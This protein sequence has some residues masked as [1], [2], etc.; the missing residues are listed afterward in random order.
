MNEPTERIDRGT[1]WHDG[2]DAATSGDVLSGLPM[3]NYRIYVERAPDKP[4][5]VRMAERFHG[6]FPS[7]PKWRM[8]ILIDELGLVE[9]SKLPDP[10]DVPDEVKKAAAFVTDSPC[11]SLNSLFIAEYVLEQVGDSNG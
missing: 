7:C 3:G 8:R 6:L 11:S 2:G 9:R 4:L 10:I 5:N 1:W